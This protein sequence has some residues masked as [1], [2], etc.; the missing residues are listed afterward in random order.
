M[1]TP[2]RASSGGIEGI[3]VRWLTPAVFTFSVLKGFLCFRTPCMQTC[4]R[5]CPQRHSGNSP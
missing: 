1:S 5:G 2:R 3:P 4:A